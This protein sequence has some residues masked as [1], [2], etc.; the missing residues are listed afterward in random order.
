M[1]V[2]T[3]GYSGTTPEGLAARLA[4]MDGRPLLVDV[5]FSPRSRVP[6]RSGSALARRFGAD[7]LHVAAL[8]NRNFKGGPIDLA[9]PEAGVAALAPILAARSVV[10][11]CACKSHEGCHR[12]DAATLLAARL[13]ARVEHLEATPRG[14]VQRRLF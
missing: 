13:G 12:S 1:T 5:R 10:L 8:G 4:E 7:Y 14:L 9:D 11:L 2:Y 3:I 6:H